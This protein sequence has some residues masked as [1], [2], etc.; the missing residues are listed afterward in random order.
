MIC[1]SRIVLG[2]DRICVHLRDDIFSQESSTILE[3]KKILLEIYLRSYSQTHIT[4]ETS[5]A[6]PFRSSAE[7]RRKAEIADTVKR[8]F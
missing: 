5:L 1:K 8:L 2:R 7:L 6:Y 4:S 3:G